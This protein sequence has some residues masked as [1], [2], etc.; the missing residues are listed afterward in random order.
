MLRAPGAPKWIPRIYRALSP[1]S[2]EMKPRPKPWAGHDPLTAGQATPKGGLRGILG[3]GHFGPG[4]GGRRT[5]PSRVR[6]G[7][8]R[9]R[10]LQARGFS[11]L[12]LRPPLK[13]AARQDSPSA[14]A[15]GCAQSSLLTAAAERA[16]GPTP[17]VSRGRAPS[18]RSLPSLEPPPPLIPPLTPPGPPT[19]EPIAVRW[20]PT[21]WHF[22]PAQPI[23]DLLLSRPPPL[24]HQMD[25]TGSEWEC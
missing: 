20:G 18:S 2:P 4:R 15:G 3:R 7:G 11:R 6:S 23:I 17:R 19:G 24:R 1:G 16:A 9:T 13:T 12:K 21:L 14:S 25:S 8:G 22:R 5:A 10:P